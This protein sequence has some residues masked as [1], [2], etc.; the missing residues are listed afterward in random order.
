MNHVTTIKMLK[1][2]GPSAETEL[3]AEEELQLELYGD[4]SLQI[5]KTPDEQSFFIAPDEAK[6]LIAGL[7]K[8]LIKV[9]S[10]SGMS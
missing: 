2:A 10:S 9:V 3:F 7:Q 1:V 4:G 5:I 6:K 8:G